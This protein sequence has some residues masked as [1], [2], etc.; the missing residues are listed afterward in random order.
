MGK[1][2][3]FCLFLFPQLLLPAPDLVAASARE[4]WLS[5]HNSYRSL[6]ES[7]PLQWSK[8]LAESA[9]D[10]AATCPTTHSTSGYGENIAWASY[11]QTPGNVVERWYREESGYAY[12]HPGFSPGIGHFTQLVWKETSQV[13]CGCRS[14]CSGRY[15]DV[16]VCHYTPPGNYQNRFA[17]NVLPP[18]KRAGEA[19]GSGD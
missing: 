8:A 2:V 19:H 14:D 9:G 4:E 10:Y 5:S 18:Q 11:V 1:Y 12:E 15:R 13:G 16:C 6:H 17:E 7:T 3:V